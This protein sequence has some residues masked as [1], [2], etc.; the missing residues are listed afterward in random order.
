MFHTYR[1]ESTGVQD[2]L[3]ASDQLYLTKY[4]EMGGRK[5]DY[6]P[7]QIDTQLQDQYF[8]YVDDE[9]GVC[10]SAVLT[11]LPYAF[12]IENQV[13][14]ESTW[15]LRNVLFHIRA[16]HPIQKQ[17]KKFSRIIK[18][19]HFGLFEH[20]WQA[21]QA[22]SHKM[23][24]SLQNDLEIHEDLQFFGGFSFKAE[25]LLEEGDQSLSIGLMPLTAKTYKAYERKKKKSLR[26]ADL[27]TSL[28][29]PQ[30]TSNV[31]RVSL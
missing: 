6:I 9:A 13:I 12:E 16:G 2:W 25:T 10:G 14:P 1:F 30:V 31:S 3:K 29:L 15:T 11:S 7:L 23:V 21:A 28:L 26:E 22:S 24:L 27:Y 5:K 18:Q 19:F 8:L 20:L 17:P 4:L